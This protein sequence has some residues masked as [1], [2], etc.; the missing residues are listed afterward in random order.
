MVARHG[1]ALYGFVMVFLGLA[2]ISRGFWSSEPDASGVILE[3]RTKV[4]D[5][6]AWSCPFPFRHLL[7]LP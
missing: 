4:N 7:I 3:F 1:V 5:G 2:G 6:A